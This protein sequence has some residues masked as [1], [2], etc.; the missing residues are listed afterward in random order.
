MKL[1]K[2]D[3]AKLA[4]FNQLNFKVINRDVLTDGFNV[5]DAK[6][7][8]NISDTIMSKIFLEKLYNH[9]AYELNMKKYGYE[10][11]FNKVYMYVDDDKNDNRIQASKLVPFNKCLENGYMLKVLTDGNNVYDAETLICINGSL[12]AIE[13]LKDL[14]KA[15]RDDLKEKMNAYKFELVGKKYVYFEDPTQMQCYK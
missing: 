11:V 12:P 15:H 14:R 7:L 9:T 1:N 8:E 10:R 5:W 3:V 13:L 2:K 4:R 6:T